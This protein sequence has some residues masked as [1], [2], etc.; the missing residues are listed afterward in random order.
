MKRLYLA[1]PMSFRAG[2]DW[3]YPAFI[4]AAGDLR[5]RGFTAWNPADL[6][7]GR[8]DLPRCQY[9]REGIKALLEQ[10][11]V[12]VLP[13][14]RDSAGA[15]LEVANAKE[16]G[17]AVLE[18]PSLEAV[19]TE[20]CLEEAQR[21]VYGSR[22]EAYAHPFDDYGRTAALWS[23]ILGTTVTP[24]KAILCMIAVKIS[25]ECHRHTRDNLVDAAGYAE[26]VQ[27]VIDGRAQRSR[28]VPL[29]NSGAF[30]TTQLISRPAKESPYGPSDP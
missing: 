6:F 12:V 24:E 23:A 7:G 27:R 15:S 16:L 3:N 9:M 18:Y 2:S 25:R 22:Q 13:G 8:T 19:K 29:G 14:W 1:G 30:P 21:L 26:C 5:A 11:A 28:S 10:D 4:A 20:T 17:L